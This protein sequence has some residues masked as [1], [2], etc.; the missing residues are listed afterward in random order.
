MTLPTQLGHGGTGFNGDDAVRLRTTLSALRTLGNEIRLDHNAVLAKLDLDGGVTDTDFASLRTVRGNAV[1]EVQSLTVVATSGDFTVTCLGATTANIAYDA[2]A[3]TVDAALVT[4]GLT[5]GLVTVSGGP[6]DAT[7]TTPYVFTYG[8]SILASD[9]TPLIATN[10]SLAGSGNGV[11]TATTVNGADP[12]VPVVAATFGQAGSFLHGDDG[13]KTRLILQ[14]LC[15]LANEIK[16]DHNGLVAK[17]DLDAGVTDATYGATTATDEIQLITITATG[18]TFTLTYE[19]QTTDAIAEAATAATVQTELEQLSNIEIGDV[20]VT[21]SAGG[22]YTLTFGGNLADENVAALTADGALLTQAVGTGTAVVATDTVGA[23]HTPT[24]ATTV[25]GVV[26]TTDEVQTVTLTGGSTTGTWDLVV[27][28]YGTI[29]AIAYNASGASVQTSFRAL[30]ADTSACTV[31][32]SGAGSSGDPYVYTITYLGTLAQTD[33]AAVTVTPNAL[34]INEVQSIAVTAVAGSFTITYAGQ[35]TAAITTSD[36]PATVQTKLEALSNLAPGD[37]AVILS[38]GALGE[39][40]WSYSLTFGGT[41]A[42]TNV[43]AVTTNVGALV[44]VG[45]A[46]PSTSTPGVQPKTIV[47]P[48]V[49]T[50][51]VDF[52]AGGANLHGVDGSGLN[53]AIGALVALLN[54]AKAKRNA[55]LAQLDLDGTVSGTNYVALHATAAADVS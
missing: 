9:V 2:D 31:V 54:E 38:A 18:G 47:A 23:A 16:A 41:L 7:G 53:T 11:T 43:A 44:A 55:A 42:V 13:V 24:V 21:G 36:V 5:N 3:A 48:D 34:G 20:V 22:P 12:I 27:P 35:T 1:N 17:L 28:V 51:R 52:G 4:A 29:A 19:G 33:V 49:A 8:D 45:T 46:V 32:R 25:P 15:T 50:I 30:H 40:T 26:A 39:P 37:V 6:G 14:A 10:V